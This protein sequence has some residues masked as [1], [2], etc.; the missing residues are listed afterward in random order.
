[1]GADAWKQIIMFMSIASM[2]LGAVGAIG[3]TNIK[4]LL[5]YS[6]IANVGFIFMGLAS[7]TLY[8]V[9]AVLFYLTVYVV[10]TLG[11]FLAVLQ[12]RDAEGRMIED[13]SGIAGLWRSRPGLAAALCVFMFSLAGIPPLFGFWPKLQVFLAAIQSGQLGLA[14]IGALASVIGA[15]YYLRVIKIILFD[16]PSGIEFPVLGGTAERGLIAGAALYVSVLGF[17]LITPLSN[18]TIAAAGSLF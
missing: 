5:A 1:M 6:S 2:V 4:R 10:M 16:P 13:I 12:L 15:Y 11:S 9:A 3:Q 14:I 17:L 8:G 18:A 7:G